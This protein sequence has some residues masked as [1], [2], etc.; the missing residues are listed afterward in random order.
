MSAFFI[1]GVAGEGGLFRKCF[2]VEA[3]LNERRDAMKSIPA[4]MVIATLVILMI[5]QVGLLEIAVSI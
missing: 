4:Y 3:K 5:A 2:T 1:T